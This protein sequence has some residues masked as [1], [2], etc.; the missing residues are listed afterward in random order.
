[1]VC[2]ERTAPT[3]MASN[4]LQIM[5]VPWEQGH[6]ALAPRFFHVKLESKHKF[7]WKPALDFYKINKLEKS[8]NR[9]PVKSNIKK[10]MGCLIVQKSIYFK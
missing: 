3:F 10:F 8:K 6:L 4:P 2:G 5:K 7:Y 1:M 9:F